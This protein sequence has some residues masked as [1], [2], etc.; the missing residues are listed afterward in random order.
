MRAVAVLT[1][2]I[3]LA[4]C[5]GVVYLYKTAELTATDV[6][7]TATPA[8]EDPERFNEIS[9]QIAGGGGLGILFSDEAPENAEDWQFITY[10]VHLKNATFLTADAVEIQITPMAGDV[11]QLADETVWTLPA[12]SEGD[13][14]VTL[15]TSS[16]MHGIREMTVRWYMNGQPFS[17]KT[18][19]TGT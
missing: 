7:M 4:A 3:F 10:T 9:R 18:R 17:L 6:R 8:T 14:K 12:R 15:M 16:R 11:L 1:A 2:I 5:G 19:A 13:L